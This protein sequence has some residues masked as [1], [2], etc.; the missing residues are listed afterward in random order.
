MNLVDDVIL[1][2]YRLAPGI[3]IMQA[4]TVF[5][6]IYEE[7]SIGR[8]SP[9]TLSALREWENRNASQSQSTLTPKSVR[10]QETS[11]TESSTKS[12]GSR[13]FQMAAL[14]QE[15]AKDPTSLLHF[16][17]TRDFTAENII[18]LMSVRE[19]KAKCRIHGVSAMYEQAIEIYA[20]SISE[21]LAEFP[22][23]IEGV[24]RTRLDS[25]FGP[26]VA[27]FKTRQTDPYNEVIPF[28][29]PAVVPLSPL[30][31]PSE[32]R[33]INKELYEENNQGINEKVFDA[34]ERSI[35]YL[36]LTNTWRKF[37]NEGSPRSSLETLRQL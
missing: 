4:V 31:S 33:I 7:Y 17:A 5:I 9:A 25:I 28:A 22:I 37:I 32:S 1:T 12:D 16:A 13:T 6:P 8:L 23:N 26:A 34:A 19:W 24:I 30:K 20:H 14:E 10:T 27:D 2:V 15:L 29:G 3:I 36:V 18:F 35:K 21:K 11:S